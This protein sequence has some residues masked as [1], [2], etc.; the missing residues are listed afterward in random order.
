MEALATR[1]E[2][3]M[4]VAVLLDT[5]EIAVKQVEYS[6]IVI[7]SVSDAKYI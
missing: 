3:S 2:A 7:K 6:L 4:Y 1:M 5:L